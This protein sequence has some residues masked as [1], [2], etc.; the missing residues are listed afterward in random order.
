M[1]FLGSGR[2]FARSIAGRQR[3]THVIAARV[4]GT[5]I[6]SIQAGS[7]E[8]TLTDNGTGD[9]TLTFRVPYKRV[10]IVVAT[11]IDAAGDASIAIK[12]VSTT[13]VNLVATDIA[14]G[15]TAK[16]VVFHVVIIGFDSADEV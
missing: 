16:D 15:P 9:Y 13:A 4:D 5:G 10:P 7:Q 12:S 2:G 1:S 6:A 3:L 11:P 8:L 14:G